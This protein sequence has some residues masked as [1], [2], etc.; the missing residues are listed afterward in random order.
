[1]ERVVAWLEEHRVG[2]R[3]TQYALRDWLFSRQRYWGEPIPMLILENGD[4]KPLAESELPLLLP[5]TPEA[6]S[7]NGDLPP[8]ARAKNWV[9]TVDLHTGRPARRETNTMPQWA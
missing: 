6:G 4:V 9:N 8:L 1:N 7:A 3:E 5:L 2:K